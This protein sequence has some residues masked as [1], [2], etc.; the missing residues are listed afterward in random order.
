MTA[1]RKSCLALALALAPAI[2]QANL[3]VNGSFEDPGAPF[4]SPTGAGWMAVAPGSTAIDGWTVGGAGID[5]H[6]GVEFIPIQDGLYAVDLNKSGGGLGD[7]GTISQTFATVAGQ[8]Y[9]LSFYFAGPN[10]GFP[11]PRQVNVNIAGG[12]TVFSQPASPNT[13]LVWGLHAMDFVATGATS[14]LTFSSV[15]GAG[16][17]G[18]VIDNV[19]VEAVAVPA[20]ASLALLALGLLGLAFR[21]RT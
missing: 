12:N 20:P 19:S 18:A 3:I 5:W 8:T 11:D 13:A 2:A 17:W 21:R 7:T 16:F 6:N 10:L 9:H 1:L 14:T 4:W 15:N